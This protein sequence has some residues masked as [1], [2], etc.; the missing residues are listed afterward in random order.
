MSVTHPELALEFHTTK[1]GN[2]LPT[3]I[4]AGTGKKLWWVCKECN[5]EWQ[6]PGARRKNRG[7]GCPA[8]SNHAVHM[9]GRNSMRSTHPIIA[10]EF[11][12]NKNG[13][14][15]PDKLLSGTN[16]RLWWK[17]SKCEHEWIASG[18]DR[19][20]GNGCPSCRPVAREFCQEFSRRP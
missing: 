8:C 2:L 13:D 11:H 20:S 12:S 14:L 15:S 19:R 18:N 10:S 9:D 7:S 1:N 3:K 4:T 5:H 6:A 16:K 17:C